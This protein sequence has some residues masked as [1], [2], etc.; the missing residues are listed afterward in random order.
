MHSFLIIFSWY[1]E[2]HTRNH[3]CWMGSIFYTASYQ[4][5]WEH[6]HLKK[7]MIIWLMIRTYHTHLL[8]TCLPST[9]YTFIG[10]FLHLI[11]QQHNENLWI[12]WPQIPW[13]NRSGR[14]FS[15]I[16]S[17]TEENKHSGPVGNASPIFIFILHHAFKYSYYFFVA[18]KSF[19]LENL[20]ILFV[21]HTTIYL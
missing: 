9:K 20:R 15:L 14:N 5:F 3:V 1:L 4:I 7:D 11:L 10:I 17:R 16:I 18:T 12:S 6:P 8:P 13:E 2:I 19:N 21:Q